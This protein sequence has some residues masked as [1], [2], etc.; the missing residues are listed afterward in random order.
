[1]RNNEAKNVGYFIAYVVPT[2]IVV[3]LCRRPPI[4][5]NK[6]ARLCI[7]RMKQNRDF[8]LHILKIFSSLYSFL[9]FSVL[10][11]R[12]PEQTIVFCLRYLIFRVKLSC[13]ERFTHAFTAYGCVFKE[14]TL[15]WVNQGN[16][17]ENA[18]VSSK[19]IRKTLVATQL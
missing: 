4:M 8:W 2:Y 3:S 13:D 7:L 16:F 10:W 15:V 1:M 5:S 19:R 9:Y 14:I 6:L 12:K 11:I 17:F 18:T